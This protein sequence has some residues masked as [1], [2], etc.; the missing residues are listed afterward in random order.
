MATEEIPRH[1]DSTDRPAAANGIWQH[2]VVGLPCF[3]GK[4]PRR[5]GVIRFR[6]LVLPV[7]FRP[8]RRMLRGRPE[9]LGSTGEGRLSER[10]YRSVA[11]PRC[12]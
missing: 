9:N 7:V 11:K 3:R 8:C 6:A 12:C 1:A 2:A 10:L 5:P 4:P